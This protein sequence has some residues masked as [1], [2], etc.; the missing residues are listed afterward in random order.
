MRRDVRRQHKPG[1]AVVTSIANQSALE[2]TQTEVGLSAARSANVAR[3]ARNQIAERA[4][5]IASVD[6]SAAN[7]GR[8]TTEKA[9]EKR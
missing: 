1:R 2:I 7:A 5:T 4:A 9:L 3:F 8:S 6:Q